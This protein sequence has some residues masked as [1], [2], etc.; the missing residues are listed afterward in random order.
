M[1]R[2]GIDPRHL[3]GPLLVRVD[4]ADLDG[5]TQHCCTAYDVFASFTNTT[6]V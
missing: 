2:V 3:G 4:H 5:K 1:G 6:Q